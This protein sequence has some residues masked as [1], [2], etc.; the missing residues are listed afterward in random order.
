MSIY[1]SKYDNSKVALLKQLLLN[2]EKSGQPMEYEIKAGELK[3]VP[4]TA[5]TSLFDLYEDYITGDTETI[6]ITLYEGHGSRSDKHIFSLKDRQEPPATSLA[7]VD[8]DRKV[9]EK[10]DAIK[11]QMAYDKVVEENKELKEQIKEAEEF[12]DKLENALKRE[13]GERLKIK[14]VHL[15]EIASVAAESLIR[16]N[17]RLL[18]RIPGGMELAGLMAEDSANKEKQDEPEEQGETT[19]SYTGETEE[20]SEAERD[21]LGALREIQER[22]DEKEQEQFFAL[23][24]LLMAEKKLIMPTLTYAARLKE[25]MVQNASKANQRKDSSETEKA[26]ETLRKDATNQAVNPIAEKEKEDEGSE[27]LPHAA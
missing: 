17:P 21:R 11:K 15:G 23:T 24:R 13:K 14:G 2:K 1:Q 12:I 20:L 3:V 26:S 16:R 10:V 7:G 6:T 22:F 25:R 9:E 27:E 19:Y 18:S 4:R 5:D 8:I